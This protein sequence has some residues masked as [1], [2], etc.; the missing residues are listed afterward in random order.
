MRTTIK[1]VSDFLV[2]PLT[3]NQI[4]ELAKYLDFENF[5]SNPSVNMSNLKDLKI[6]KAEE[7]GFIRKGKI[8]GANE[9]FTPMLTKML[10]KW[11]DDGYETLNDPDFQFPNN[12]IKTNKSRNM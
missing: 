10:E 3:E 12:V 5:R 6:I 1:K 8:N 4:N 11:I 9:E 7:Q 2:K